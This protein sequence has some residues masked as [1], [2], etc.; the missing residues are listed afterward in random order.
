MTQTK[1]CY[2]GET[3]MRIKSTEIR[4][5][6][7]PEAKRLPRTHLTR[8]LKRVT[9]AESLTR[10][11]CELTVLKVSVPFFW[12]LSN[13]WNQLQGVQVFRE[14]PYLAEILEGCPKSSFIELLAK[15][16]LLLIGRFLEDW[17]EGAKLWMYS[18]QGPLQKDGRDGLKWTVL[19][20][21]TCNH[22]TT[23]YS[24]CAYSDLRCQMIWCL[25]PS[26]WSACI[27]TCGA[28]LKAILTSVHMTSSISLS[29][30][31]FDLQQNDQILREKFGKVAVS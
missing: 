7:N 14:V 18:L 9:Y 31:T 3:L 21:M 29:K 1:L 2:Q 30:F 13:E 25:S 4:M 11:T 22:A 28:T 20:L 12:L 23:H 15:D 6:A 8:L 16:S 10:Q 19:D 24:H 5:H 17:R 26:C 27:E